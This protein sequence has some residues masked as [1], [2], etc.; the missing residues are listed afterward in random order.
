LLKSIALRPYVRF[1]YLPRGMWFRNFSDQSERIERGLHAFDIAA[2]TGWQNVEAALS[3]YR[4]LPAAFF[5]I[6]GACYEQ[7]RSS[8]LSSRVEPVNQPVEPGYAN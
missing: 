1:A 4:I 2:Q 7:L 8:L 3:N 5:G 6:P